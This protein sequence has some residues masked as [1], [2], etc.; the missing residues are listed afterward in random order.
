MNKV[1]QRIAVTEEWISRYADSISAPL[2]TLDGKW[3]APA[4]MP[5]I[6]W[7]EFDI[8]WLKADGPWIHGSQ[9]FAYSAPITAGMVLDCEL[10]LTKV[11]TK[12]GR[13]GMLTLYTH[14]LACCSGG[15]LIVTAETVLIR[16]GE[17]HEHPDHG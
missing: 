15:D 1:R 16:A 4:T 11:E 8:P 12:E 14:T 9:R 6:F 3:M 10:S 17:R 13:L 7:Q 2:Q 5:V